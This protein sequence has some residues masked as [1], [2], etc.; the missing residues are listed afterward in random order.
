MALVGVHHQRVVRH[1]LEVEARTRELRRR[2]PAGDADR[3]AAGAADERV[4]HDR[5]AAQAK[6]A[7]QPLETD[8]QRH[9]SEGREV[10]RHRASERRIPRRAA[11]GEHPDQPPAHVAHG[12]GELRHRVERHAVGAHVHDHRRIEQARS[13][14]RA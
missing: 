3:A 1:H 12:V 14:H 9:Q 13:R 11:R 5:V 10:E 6:R 2:E 8:A 7:E 4:D